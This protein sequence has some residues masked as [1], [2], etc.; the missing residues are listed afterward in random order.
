MDKP[1]RRQIS[2]PAKATV[3]VEQSGNFN[4]WYNRWSGEGRKHNPLEKAQRRCNIKKDMGY[5]KARPGALFCVHFSRGCCMKGE[6]CSYW[7]RAPIPE[8]IEDQTHDCFGRERF[9]EDR[10]DMGGVGSFERD[11][12]TLYV[13]NI[14][15]PR[16]DMEETVRRHFGDWGEIE[17][18]NILFGKNVAFVRYVRRYNAEFAREAMYGQSL[19]SNEV[20]NVRWATDDPNPHVKH[21]KKRKVEDHISE[22]VRA[23]LPQIGDLGTVLDY[24]KHSYDY[25]VAG[26]VAPEEPVRKAIKVAGDGESET[27]AFLREASDAVF[28]SGAGQEGDAANAAATA[29]P[30]WTWDGYG[31]RATGTAQTATGAAKT[32]GGT[33]AT[34]GAYD[35]ETVRWYLANGYTIDPAMA[36]TIGVTTSQVEGEAEAEPAQSE[37]P[38][39]AGSKLGALSSLAAGYGSDDDE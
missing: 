32:T 9:R 35:E 24:E 28:D 5:T 26:P 25:A 23:S 33:T 29:Y 2:G 11:N 36:D 39:A 19:D 12:R 14:K 22:T 38:V 7:H 3:S 15:A 37:E 31:W 18:T 27:A 17:H 30:G 1:A 10:D 4:I 21:L 34:G 20:L 13:G 16:A 8:D 6:Q